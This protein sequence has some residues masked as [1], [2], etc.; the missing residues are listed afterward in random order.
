MSERIGTAYSTY[1]IANLMYV[2]DL[3]LN[4]RSHH[5]WTRVC[6]FECLPGRQLCYS[7]LVLYFDKSCNT[8]SVLKH[9]C[10]FLKVI[11][12]QA[13]DQNRPKVPVYDTKDKSARG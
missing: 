7:L 8:S 11:T 9:I 3:C 5:P 4:T 12:S 6:S 1:C 2:I 10:L 13:R